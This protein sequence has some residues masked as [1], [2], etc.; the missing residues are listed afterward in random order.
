[1]RLRTVHIKNTKGVLIMFLKSKLKKAI[2]ASRKEIEL[3]EQKRNRSQAALL[4]ALLNKTTPDDVD[5]EYFNMFTMEIENERE[6]MH[7][8]I[9]ELEK[10]G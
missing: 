2:K 7:K 1:M 8:L 4:D 3:L 6:H 10:L 9:T 5:V